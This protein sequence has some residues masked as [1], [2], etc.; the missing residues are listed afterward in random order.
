[1]I[2]GSYPPTLRPLLVRLAQGRAAFHIPLYPRLPVASSQTTS[3]AELLQKVIVLVVR[4][5][6]W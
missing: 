5:S 2:S 4:E 3:A 1:M 6:L